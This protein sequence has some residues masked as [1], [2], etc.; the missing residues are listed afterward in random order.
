MSKEGS[1]ST[2]K[3][4]R[5]GEEGEG[6][7]ALRKIKA[8]GKKDRAV[9]SGARRHRRVLTIFGSGGGKKEGQ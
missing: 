4:G 7:I 3:K 1:L 8:D 2:S 9:T 6:E 5:G